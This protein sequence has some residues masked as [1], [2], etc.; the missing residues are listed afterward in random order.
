MVIIHGLNRD[1]QTYISQALSALSQVANSS[2]INTDSVAIVAPYFLDGDDENIGY[3]LVDNLRPTQGSIT[4]APVW[5][6]STWSAGGP[7]Q[8]PWTSSKNISSYTVLDQV[9]QY[10]DNVTM[11]PNM[12]QIVIAGHSLGAQTV[13][14]Y[15][16]IGQP[17]PT[18]SPVSYWV[19]NPDSFV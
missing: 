12:K 11:F 14:R 15:A 19:A 16:A 7:N 5:D 1:P 18:N 10:F 8:Y 2:D 13:Q 6:G 17:G 3:P 4:N 9:I